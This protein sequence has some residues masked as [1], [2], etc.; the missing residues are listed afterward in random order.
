LADEETNHLQTFF[1]SAQVLYFGFFENRSFFDDLVQ[2]AIIDVSG[3]HVLRLPWLTEKIANHCQPPQVKMQQRF[4]TRISNKREAR[5][6]F[7]V[8]VFQDSQKP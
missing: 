3:L 8:E 5:D 4:R 6:A 2:F 7:A 1:A